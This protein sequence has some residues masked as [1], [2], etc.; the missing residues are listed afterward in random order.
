MSSSS[1][2]P[3]TRLLPCPLCGGTASLDWSAAAEYGGR[4]W[5]TLH[6]SCNGDGSNSGC[7]H[8]VSL[9]TDSDRLS[10]K[11]SQLEAVLARTWNQVA[12][13]LT[14]PDDSRAMPGFI[15]AEVARALHPQ[16]SVEDLRRGLEVEAAMQG[17]ASAWGTSSTST[18]LE[19][20]AA[21]IA[22]EEV[23]RG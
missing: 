2:Q 5:Q 3:S 19:A 9:D 10:G 4:A 13:A 16:A 14:L 6:V 1:A 15:P 12:V 21:R 17:L 20:A 18:L 8:A 7:D 22:T 11:A 23:S